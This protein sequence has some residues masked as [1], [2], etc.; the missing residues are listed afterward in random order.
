M[1]A[2]IKIP[3][4]LAEKYHYQPDVARNLLTILALSGILSGVIFGIL[5]KRFK[6]LTLPIMLSFHDNWKYVIYFN[7]QYCYILYR[8]Y[9]YRNQ[10]C[11]N[12][13]HLTSSIFLISLENKFINFATSVILVG[14]N[15]G[16]IL[17]PVV[18]TKIPEALHL[19]KYTTPFFI[20]TTLML[21]STLVSY[22]VLRNKK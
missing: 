1:G 3:T 11:W 18:L 22:T 20:T 9:L 10:L 4:L 17:T 19:E 12:D 21:I 15:I 14:G 5:V 6:N 16:V 8:S 13:V 2:T 7:K